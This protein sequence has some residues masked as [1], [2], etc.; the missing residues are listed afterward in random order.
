M[1]YFKPQAIIFTRLGGIKRCL[2][3]MQHEKHMET[4]PYNCKHENSL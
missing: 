4:Q 3:D 2:T 1:K